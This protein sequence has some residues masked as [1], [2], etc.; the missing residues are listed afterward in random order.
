MNEA[1]KGDATSRSTRAGVV[2]AASRQREVGELLR[3]ATDTN[4]LR[5]FQILEIS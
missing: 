1:R 5:L 2:R 3:Q 4:N